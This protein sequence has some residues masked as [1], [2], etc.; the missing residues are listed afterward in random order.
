MPNPVSLRPEIKLGPAARP[1]SPI[2][3]ARP[4]LSNIHKAGS[5]ILPKTGVLE[6]NQPKISPITSAPPLVVKVTETPNNVTESK[7]KSPPRTIPSPTK[8]ISVSGLKRSR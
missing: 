4:T 2:K 6:C 3:A 1:T 5:G 8:I 7:P